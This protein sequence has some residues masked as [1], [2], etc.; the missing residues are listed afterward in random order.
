MQTIEKNKRVTIQLL[1]EVM[2][3]S[4]NT[5]SEHIKRLMQKGYVQKE[6]NL[7]DKRIVQVKLTTPGKEALKR[8]TELDEQKLQVI[9]ERLSVEDQAQVLKA[10]ELLSKEARHVFSS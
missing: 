6:R 8:N 7:E 5:A 2:G 1:S 3:I 4:H 9:L 10:F